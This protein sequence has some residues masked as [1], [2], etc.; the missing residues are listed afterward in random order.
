MMTL[1][2][3]AIVAIAGVV[4]RSKWSLIDVVPTKPKM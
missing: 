4:H 3:T 2:N 1:A